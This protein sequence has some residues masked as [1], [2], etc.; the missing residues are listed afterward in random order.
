MTAQP[1]TTTQT[2]DGETQ[3][4]LADIL[5]SQGALDASR[6]QQ[7]KTIE[8]QT[9]KTQEEIV[10]DKNLVPEAALVRAK[11]ALYNIAYIDLAKT[12]A[13][14]EALA[15]LAQEVAERFRV[16]P[17]SA[18]KP[19]KQLVLA[20]ADPLDLTAIE[21]VEQKTGLQVMPRAA[22]PSKIDDFISTRY[23]GSLAQEVTEAL[24]EVSP[25]EEK[26]KALE[27]TKTGFIR[28]EKVAE[29]V[30]HMLEFA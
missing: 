24:K 3:G 14:P 12:P 1:A 29:I 16:F 19:S 10:K 28:E 7:V 2:T 23:V 20:M 4:S 8:I 6:A 30:R 5:V 26:V 25:G 27:R 11:A 9:G 18:D 17:I 13:S 22:E 15:I 21:F